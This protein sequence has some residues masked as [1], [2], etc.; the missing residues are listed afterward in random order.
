M[1][2]F[3]FGVAN[4]LKVK[5]YNLHHNAVNIHEPE[6]FQQSMISAEM[7]TFSFSSSNA[8]FQY[9]NTGK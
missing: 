3:T 5:F 6:S 4:L 9:I 1:P 7:S 2:F 8:Q